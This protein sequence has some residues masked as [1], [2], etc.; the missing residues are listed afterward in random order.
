MWE[1]HDDNGVIFQGTAAEM[2]F[3]WDIN[4][5]ADWA[6]KERYMHLVRNPKWLLKEWKGKLRLIQ[7]LSEIERW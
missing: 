7:V 3:A 1:I 5:L 6:F 4:H 2:T